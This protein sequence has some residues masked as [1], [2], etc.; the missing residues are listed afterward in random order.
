MN[1]F[2]SDTIILNYQENNNLLTSSWKN[3]ENAEQFIDGIKNC[4]EVC[5]KV[6]VSNALW[7]FNDFKFIISDDLQKWKDDFLNRGVIKKVGVFNKLAFV[8]G[9]DLLA[10]LSGVDPIE[11]GV[12]VITPRCFTNEKQALEYIHSN[13]T[14]VDILQ[15]LQLPKLSIQ[16]NEIDQSKSQI[17]IDVNSDQI[18]EYLFILNRLFKS[19]TFA[20]KHISKFLLL[21]K[22]EKEIL[23]LVI[24]GNTNEYIANHRN[25]AYETIKT[26]R[27]NIFRKL[28]CR[29]TKSLA[30]YAVFI[31]G[32]EAL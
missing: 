2:E 4:K 14:K 17:L 18:Y 27:K 9:K 31:F 21:T 15:N 28:E 12:G 25:V 26:H 30:K 22:S 24:C 20:L 10:L 7:H 19:K 6:N 29:N 11:N 5:D 16:T 3:C 13:Q 8:M 1:L 23:K 32:T